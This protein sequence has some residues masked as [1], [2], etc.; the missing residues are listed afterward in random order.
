MA[1]PLTR[2]YLVSYMLLTELYYA[3]QQKIVIWGVLLLLVNLV[4]VTLAIALQI[5]ES[6]RQ[7]IIHLMLLEVRAR[8]RARTHAF[9]KAKGSSHFSSAA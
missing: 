8:R 1:P 9:S 5:S 7:T 6:S 2:R 4:T 3:R